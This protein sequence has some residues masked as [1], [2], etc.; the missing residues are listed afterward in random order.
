MIVTRPRGLIDFVDRPPFEERMMVYYADDRY[1]PI[2]MARPE[3]GVWDLDFSKY[4]LALSEVDEPANPWPM[5]PRASFEGDIGNLDTLMPVVKLD[6][7]EHPEGDPAR[8]LVDG[9]DSTN[10]VQLRMEPDKSIVAGPD[11]RVPLSSFRNA[12]RESKMWD[13]SSEEDSEGGSDDEPLARVA[14]KR[15]DPSL[16]KPDIPA[17]PK[18]VVTH[19]RARSQPGTATLSTRNT[20]EAEFRWKE[21]QQKTAAAEVAKARERREAA[22]S[23]ETERRAMAAQRRSEYDALPLAK[24]S[25]TVDLSNPS[26]RR[27]R[28][29]SS[30]KHLTTVSR[31]HSSAINCRG[32]IETVL[33]LLRGS[34]GFD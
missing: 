33:Q 34:S 10:P 22:M 23:G 17:H 2:S 12:R 6:S 7:T 13:Y 27:A 21:V 8:C 31:S 1:S 11:P 15:S 25:S 9:D 5:I 20:R 24:R 14:K 28:H 19:E 26:V 18:L 16:L 29:P 4:I 3:H 30:G 32:S